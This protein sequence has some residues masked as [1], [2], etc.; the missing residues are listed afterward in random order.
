ML[1]VDPA[2][3]EDAVSRCQEST[4]GVYLDSR[5]VS[6]VWSAC[7]GDGMDDAYPE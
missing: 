3:E 4:V 6:E 7:S 5:T 2:G 1:D